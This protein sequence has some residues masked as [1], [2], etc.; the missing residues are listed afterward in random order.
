MHFI[1]MLSLKLD[2]G[3]GYALAETLIPLVAAV[4]ATSLALVFVAKDHKN[5]VRLI[6]AGTVFGLGVAFMH[7]LGMAGMRFG[8]YF[9]WNYGIAAVSFLIAVA[10]ATVVL[11]LALNTKK[12]QTR[13]IASVIMGVVVSAMHYTG[14]SAAS[15]ICTTPNRVALP[16]G[17][18][19]VNS[20]DLP[21]CFVRVLA[22]ETLIAGP[23]AAER[24]V[25]R[26]PLRKPCRQELLMV[27]VSRI[28]FT[29]AAAHPATRAVDDQKP[30]P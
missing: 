6:L 7:Y 27:L 4:A 16:V 11:W 22:I 15:F 10:A 2:I 24:H 25:H 26:Q 30:A 20:A 9:S 5:N 17:F 19:V 23:G 13:L 1:G 12:L 28:I 8:R 3:T 18:V 21:A 29:L 14:M